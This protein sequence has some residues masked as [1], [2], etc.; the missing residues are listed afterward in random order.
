[1]LFM[2]PYNNGFITVIFKW[3]NTFVNRYFQHKCSLGP[4]DGKGAV[5]SACGKVF[6]ISV[7]DDRLNKGS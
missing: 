3:I 5:P 2:L 6:P 4:R 7:V 1:M